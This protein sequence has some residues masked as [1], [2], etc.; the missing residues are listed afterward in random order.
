MT[1][2]KI[3]KLIEEYIR[4]KISLN[5]KIE[6]IEK[7]ENKITAELTY[8][9]PKMVFDDSLQKQFIKFIKLNNFYEAKFS[10]EAT[11]ISPLFD[12]KFLYKNRDLEL[13][14][15]Q[16]IV[17]NLI[18]DTIYPKL[19][20]IP[21]IKNQL[22]PIYTILLE[23]ITNGKMTK[24]EL[25]NMRKQDRIKKYVQFLEG[26]GI[27][28]KDTN[29]DLVEGNIPIE[30]KDRIQKH[31]DN[32][33]DIVSKEEVLAC[34]FGYALKEGKKYL[35]EELRL[36]SVKPFLRLAVFYYSMA[37]QTNYLN[38][39]TGE[40]FYETYIA[41]NPEIDLIRSQLNNQLQDMVNA[42]ILA[43]QNNFFL[44]KKDILTAVI[45]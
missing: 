7:A 8:F 36:T 41:E 42:G 3:K 45:A 26:L 21:L 25:S 31:R 30:L 18:F 2:T 15:Q 22:T 35:L 27:I 13:K 11:G 32:G 37:S 14:K 24:T 29:G 17:E 16:I 44:G 6:K 20:R 12:K 28:R 4:R 43:R 33:I 10:W 40:T 39:M 5:I 23:V 9:I 34:T 19:V 38:K 1:Q